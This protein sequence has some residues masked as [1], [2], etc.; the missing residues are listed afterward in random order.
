MNYL[1]NINCYYK[2][3]FDYYD[4]LLKW[5]RNFNSK[6]KTYKFYLYQNKLENIRVMHNNNNNNS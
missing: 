2:I 5:M 3:S 1:S 4:N 6:F